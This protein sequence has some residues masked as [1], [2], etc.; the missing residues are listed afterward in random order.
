MLLT[1]V[2]RAENDTDKIEYGNTVK[3]AS[4]AIRG[5]RMKLTRGKD[6]KVMVEI[7]N[8]EIRL[9]YLKVK[10]TP[11][12]PDMSAAAPSYEVSAV[13]GVTTVSIGVKSPPSIWYLLETGN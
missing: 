13:D 11:L 7:V 10:V 2:S 6:G 8:A 1:A 3:E 12:A 4:G 5:E 9:K